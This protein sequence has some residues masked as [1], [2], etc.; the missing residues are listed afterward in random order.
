MGEGTLQ[1][2]R[3]LCQSRSVHWPDLPGPDLPLKLK[4]ET[5]GLAKTKGEVKYSQGIIR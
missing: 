3:W 4:K 5:D 2:V 1:K